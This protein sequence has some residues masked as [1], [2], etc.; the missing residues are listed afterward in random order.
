MRVEAQTRHA[1]E[2]RIVMLR[3][4]LALGNLRVEMAQI[5]QP[6]RRAE[7]VHLR[8][9]ADEGHGLRPVYAEVLEVL[10]ALLKRAVGIAQRAAL[11][12]VEHLRGVEGEH[13]DIPERGGADAAAPDAEGVRRV[14]EH[15]QAVRLGNAVDS[16][17]IAEVAVNVHGHDGDGLIRD[18]RLYLRD[19]DGIIVGVY[20]AEHRRAADARDG[21]GGGGKGEGRGDDLTAAQGE[22]LQHVF[23]REVAVGEERDV[24]HAQ[25]LAQRA[26]QRLMLHA[27][28][29]EPAAVPDI[30]DL[31]TEFVEIRHGGAGDIDLF[32]HSNLLIESRGGG[33]ARQSRRLS[34]MSRSKTGMP[35]LSCTALRSAKESSIKI[36]FGRM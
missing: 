9:A 16:V 1:A 12:G 18:E 29:S 31:R 8:V 35:Q 5:A 14:V 22:G 17:N 34:T 11:N 20:V 19:I 13:G 36:E 21:V 7:L 25:I 24:R 33:Q 32:V 2:T 30:P 6:H 15:M 28:I 26:L 3:R 27:H 23:K 4:E 10:Q